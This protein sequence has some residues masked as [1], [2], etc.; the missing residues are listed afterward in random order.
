M[1]AIALMLLE[2][3]CP[4]PRL[5]SRGRS[6]LKRLHTAYEPLK[7]QLPSWQ[8]SE[9]EPARLLLVG[10]FGLSVLDGAHYS[11]YQQLFPKATSSS[12]LDVFAD[13]CGSGDGGDGGD[14]GCWGCGD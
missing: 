2:K 4:T 14:G 13:G 6:Y 8:P 10:L 1:A 5:S 3:I 7:Q 9:P 12:S 11:V